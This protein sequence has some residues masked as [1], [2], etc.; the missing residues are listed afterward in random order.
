MKESDRSKRR[1]R[2]QH[3]V[4]AFS[5][6]GEPASRSAEAAIHVETIAARSRLHAWKIRPHRHRDLYQVL[7]LWRGSMTAELDGTSTLLTGPAYVIVPPLS[8]HAFSFSNDTDGLVA[9]FSLGLGRELLDSSLRHGSDLPQA[10]A[11]GLDRT[12]AGTRQL[13]ALGEVMLQEGA[14]TAPGRETVLRGLLA[15]LVTLMLRGSGA[16]ATTQG[17]QASRAAELVARFRESLEGGYTDHKPVRAY[18]AALNTTETALRR[19]CKRVAAQSPREMQLARKLIEAERL[20]RYTG[21]SIGQIA[22][23]L[24]FDDPAYFSRFFLRRSGVSPRAFRTRA[25]AT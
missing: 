11:G 8:V 2:H 6:Y 25:P 22:H 14:R 7:L 17:G 9:T 15:A 23:Q 13:R 21:L 3:G 19:A 4:P 5:L 20:L 18:A 12:E 10:S 24:G 1:N 16:R